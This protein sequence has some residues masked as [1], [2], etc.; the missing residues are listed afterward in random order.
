MNKEFWQLIYIWLIPVLWAIW[1]GYWFVSSR[2]VHCTTKSESSMSRGI[3]LVL[4]CGAFVL[5]AI[6]AF[7]VGPLSWH[8]LPRLRFVF[9]FGAAVLVASLILAVWA[10]RHLGQYWSGTI[11]VKEEHR[12]IRSGPYC[13]VRHPIYT[14]FVGGMIGTAIAQ[15]ELRGIFSVLL[16]I[17][18]YLRK[19][20]IEE[21]WLVE[22]FGQTYVDYRKK[23]K[24][25][26]P[27]VI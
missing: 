4:V 20:R 16:L 15:G 12:L 21:K 11:T 23:V 1:W 7:R 8:W 13:F 5:I 27:F 24:A 10:R 25:L 6:P 19:I 17:A 18:A 3:H 26:I 22:R 14:G 2:N 9:F